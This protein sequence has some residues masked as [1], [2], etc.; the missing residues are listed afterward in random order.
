VGGIENRWSAGK[1]FE[2]DALI[3]VKEIRLALS[4]WTDRLIAALV[5]VLGLTGLHQALASRPL[6]AA[7]WVVSALAAAI[8]ILTARLLHGRL[9]FQ[10]ND[11]ILAHEALAAGSRRRYLVSCHA[12]AA[13]ALGM[14]VLTARVGLVAFVLP[15]YL[16]GAAAGTLASLLATDRGSRLRWFLVATFRRQMQRPVTGILAAVVVL[17]IAFGGRALETE[18]RLALVGIA[19]VCAVLILTSVDDAVVRFMTIAGYSAGRIVGAR[20]RPALIFLA[21]TTCACLVGSERFEAGI[22]AAV[23]VIGLLLMIARILAYRSHPKRAADLVVTICL[24][25]VGVVGVTV[26][27]LSPFAFAAILWQLHRRSRRTTWLLA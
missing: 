17:G 2:H 15:G 19:T 14:A 6:L 22:I 24:G 21:I 7:A 1:L 12:L 5:V 26:P 3:V 8:G 11:G 13:A 9:V 27:V 25:V 20:A 23:G 4:S 18:P 16:A 10:I